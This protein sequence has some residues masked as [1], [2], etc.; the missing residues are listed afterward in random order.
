MLAIYK[1]NDSIEAFYALQ[2]VNTV[3]IRLKNKRTNPKHM[4]IIHAGKT[5]AMRPISITIFLYLSR[6]QRE[7]L[8]LFICAIFLILNFN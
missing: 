5:M 6:K 4:R 1:I 2:S 3:N 8:Q 7:K